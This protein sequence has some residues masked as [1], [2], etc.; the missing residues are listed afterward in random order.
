[1][2]NLLLDEQ[3]SPVVAEQVAARRPEISV[4]SFR[5]WEGGRHLNVGFQDAALLTRAGEQGLTLVTYDRR[6]ITPLLMSLAE[7]GQSHGGVVFVDE[8]TIASNDFGGLVRALET[9]WDERG[10]EDWRDQWHY[11]ERPR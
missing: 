10:R 1:M 4:L 5:D 2:L 7:N 9:L 6:T 11:L 8:R 3:I